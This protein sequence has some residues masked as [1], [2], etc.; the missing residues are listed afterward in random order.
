VL[1]SKFSV[2]RSL[3]ILGGRMVR[4]SPF[5]SLLLLVCLVAPAPADP[6]PSV[7][8]AGPPPPD[9]PLMLSRDASGKATVRAIKLARPLTVDGTLDHELYQ[10]D[11]PF[12]A[13]LA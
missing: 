7:V 10:T 1:S 9:P 12:A 6:Q 2:L 3:V 13:S 5:A 8:I 4:P 11:Q